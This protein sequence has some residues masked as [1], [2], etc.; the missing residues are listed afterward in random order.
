MCY[1]FGGSEA[2][3]ATKQKASR[4]AAKRKVPCTTI[5][6][7]SNNEEHERNIIHLFHDVPTRFVRLRQTDF[8]TPEQRGDVSESMLSVGQCASMY[9]AKK[10]HGLPLLLIKGGSAITYLG[11]DNG[12]KVIGGG[13]CPGMSIRCR[14]LF[15]YCHKDFPSLGFDRYKEITDKAKLEK[16]PMSLFASDVEAGIAAN[17]TAELAGHLRNIVK[18]FLKLVGPAEFPATV[19]VTGDDTEILM[20]LLEENCSGMIETESDVVF[21]PSNKVIFSSSKN[22]APYG[23]KHLLQQNKKQQSPPNPDDE[24]RED[25]IGLRVVTFKK[26]RKTLYRGSISRVVPGK[27]LEE[28]TFGVLLDDGE[29]VFLDL[30]QLYGTLSCGI[31]SSTLVTSIVSPLC[32]FANYILACMYFLFL[33]AYQRCHGFV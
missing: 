29:K 23:V 18:Q 16:Q 26:S 6:I 13:A 10:D 27:V 22:M 28:D 2:K 3:L 1:I 8:F 4:M 30:V 7:L 12:S 32:L 31:S 9:A 5:Y 11:M 21:P 20:Q 17:A 14:A 25:L 19:V 15:D 24:I 33:A